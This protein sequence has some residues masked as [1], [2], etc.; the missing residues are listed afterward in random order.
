[1]HFLGGFFAGLATL[2][3][4]YLAGFHKQLS[5]ASSLQVM[6]V[7]LIGALTVGIFWEIFEYLAGVTFDVLGNY[8]LDTA[9]DLTMDITGGYVSYLFFVF[10]KYH[11]NVY[12]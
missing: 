6:I 8:A 10:K 1:M 2:W 11:K 3:F 4:Y 12:E 9:K 7:A 5:A